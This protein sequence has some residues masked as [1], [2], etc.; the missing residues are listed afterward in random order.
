MDQLQSMES[1]VA[2]LGPQLA[3]LKKSDGS[4][5][6]S[7]SHTQRS[8]NPGMTETVDEWERTPRT[9][10]RNNGMTETVD[11]WERTPRTQT[12]NNGLTETVDEW[13][14]TPRTQTIPIG[15][16]MTGADES[17]YRNADTEYT[18]PGESIPPTTMQGSMHR[19]AE[20]Q[21]GPIT[22]EGDEFEDEET[23]TEG[24][25]G[26]RRAYTDRTGPT[27]TDFLSYRKRGDLLSSSGR[28]ESPGQQVL[29][30]E[31]Y[32]LRIK[33]QA[34]STAMTHQSWELHEE[35]VNERPDSRVPESEIPDIEEELP[36]A[37]SPPLPP[38][39]VESQT[40][41][42]ADSGTNERQWQPEY[43]EAP[44]TPPWQRIHQRL[45]N[46]AIVWPMSELDNAMTSTQRGAQAD[47]VALS[48]WSTQMYKRYVRQQLT[49]V[50]PGR[51][52]RLFVPPNM[53]D[54]INNA[55][56]HGRHGDACGM[57]RDLWMPFGLEGM[58][59]IIVVL[60]KHRSDPSHWVA[61]KYVKDCV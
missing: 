58:P 11:E 22:T 57:L 26:H 33:E 44:P 1:R 19:L 16:Q 21:V 59:R 60:C 54:A 35:S 17:M 49:E 3:K 24:R 34:R 45:L 8:R 5:T 55:V 25:N 10:P 7:Q 50:P 18:V 42:N 53:A 20:S 9:Q 38:I 28:G 12:R 36:R 40:A 56:F 39:P 32:R 52:D 15:T 29:E 13:D 37:D 46:W 4:R 6:R 30:E 23:R 61:H 31:L 2:A 48:I 14:R 27:E 41:V 47:E 43:H 51:V